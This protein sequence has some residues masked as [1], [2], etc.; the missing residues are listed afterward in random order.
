MTYTNINTVIELEESIQLTNFLSRLEGDKLIYE[1]RPLS[2]STHADKVLLSYEEHE[3]VFELAVDEHV[4]LVNLHMKLTDDKEYI[5][6]MDIFSSVDDLTN[7]KEFGSKIYTIL[8]RT[9][10]EKFKLTINFS[11][12]GEITN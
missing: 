11:G 12:H 2:K 5:H 7:V 8:S 3:C 4:V 1:L 10:D 6:T 9:I